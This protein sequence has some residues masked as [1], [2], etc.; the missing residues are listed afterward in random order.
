MPTQAIAGEKEKRT[1]E[2][3]LASPASELEI[4]LGK[5]LASV[6]PAVL[7][8]WIFFALFALGVDL[9]SFHL[10]QHLLVPNST[11]MFGMVVLAPLFSLFGNAVAVAISARVNDPRLAQQLAALCV[12]P[13]VGVGAATLAGLAQ[14]GPYFYGGLAPVMAVLDVLVLVLAVRL[15]D[16]ERIL[17]R[18]G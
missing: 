9:L 8:T 5:S 1:I 12:M 14:L 18:W 6:F 10:L 15:F 4:L 17:T 16:R 11:W 13:V 2:P 7:I 3:L